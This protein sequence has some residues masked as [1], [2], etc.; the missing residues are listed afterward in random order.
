MLFRD[1]SLSGAHLIEIE[2]HADAR[3]YFARTW[4]RREF[5][6]QN[7]E[8]EYVQA[9]VSVNPTR[10]TLRGLHF[11]CT[12]HW[13]VKVVQCIRGAIHDVIVDLRPRS[14][15]FRQWLGVTL[16]AESRDM[17]YVPVGFA[18]GFQTLENDTEVSYLVSTF[19]VPAA[20]R[21]IRYD[22]P[23]LGIDWPLEV[24]RISDTDRGLPGIDDVTGL[25]AAGGKR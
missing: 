2:R 14:P 25:M 20:A 7:L 1:L 17:L 3:G 5:R 23:A 15:T 11:Q 19:Y 22:D 4:C 9:S 13:E 24:T 8:T 18:H 12:P 21:G 16:S 10:G 6:K